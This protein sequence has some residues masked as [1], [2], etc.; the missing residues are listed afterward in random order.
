MPQ[1]FRWMSGRISSSLWTKTVL[2]SGNS[3]HGLVKLSAANFRFQSLCACDVIR[4]YWSMI[5]FPTKS[6]VFNRQLPR[7]LTDPQKAQSGVH[8]H[9]DIQA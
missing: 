9:G 6:A 5:R 4:C 1:N 2:M 3:P 8:Y 7:C